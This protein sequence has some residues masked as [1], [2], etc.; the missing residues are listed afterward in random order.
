MVGVLG[1][2]Q[3]RHLVRTEGAL[4]L[5]AVDDFR[6]RPALG[7]P[8]DDHGPAR[9]SEVVLAPGIALDLPD[10]LD[11]LVQSAGHELMHLFRIVTF[12]EVGRPAAAPQELLQFLMLD[13]GQDGR[14]ADLVAIEVQDRQHGSVVDRG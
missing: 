3:D 6:S 13:A 12:H 11:G 8:Q 7:R 10:V 4:D 2:D 14:V 1:I 5:Q 9:P